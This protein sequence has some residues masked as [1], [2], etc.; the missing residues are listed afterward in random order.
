MRCVGSWVDLSFSHWVYLNWLVLCSADD[1]LFWVVYGYDWD[2]LMLTRLWQ[3]IVCVQETKSCCNLFGRIERPSS[4]WCSFLVL[5]KFLSMEE[6]EVKSSC[7]EGFQCMHWIHAMSPTQHGSFDMFSC[8]DF[9]G[10]MDSKYCWIVI[11]MLICSLVFTLLYLYP[12]NGIT[13]DNILQD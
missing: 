11:F 9:I 7:K 10:S 12:S 3:A 5:I 4:H 8:V 1:R 2:L 6:V 13:F